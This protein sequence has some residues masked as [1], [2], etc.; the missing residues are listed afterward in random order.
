MAGI[1]ASVS[2]SGLSSGINWKDMVKQ[3]MASESQPLNALQGQQAVANGKQQ[4]YTSL[5]GNLQGLQTAAE[6]LRQYG[7]G[8]L[9]TVKAVSSD[10]SVAAA[11]AKPGALSGG[12]SLD[13]QALATEARA[14][15]GP[16]VYSSAATTSSAPVV[17]GKQGLAGGSFDPSASLSSESGAFAAKPGGSG[18][19]TVNGK[20]IRWTDSDS[21]GD[22][23]A[24][25][26]ASG[27]G[28]VAKI[29][30]DGT[31]TLTGAQSGA[32]ASIT[33]GESSGSLLEAL[34]MEPGRTAGSVPHTFDP[35]APL[36]S[37]AKFLGTPVTAGRVTINGVG[38][39]IDP[40]KQSLNDILHSFNDNG[41][42]VQGMFDVTD[43]QLQF[44]SKDQGAKARLEL[45]AVGDS[46]NFLSAFKVGD[47]TPGQDALVS[48]NGGPAQSLSS[49]TTD[50]LLPGASIALKSLGQATVSVG[51]SGDSAADA[52]QQFVDSYNT[53]VK[54][55]A[56][57]LDETPPNH[58]KKVDPLA[59]VNPDELN[60]PP[61]LQGAFIGDSLLQQTSDTL[62]DQVIG[63]LNGGNGLSLAQ[64][65]LTMVGNGPDQPQ[66]L[67]FDKN[68]FTAALASNPQAVHA[69]ISAP[70]TGLADRMNT[71][72]QGLLDPTNGSYALGIKGQTD[73]LND[74]NGQIREMQARLNDRQSRL[75]DQYSNLEATLGA[76]KAQGQSIAGTM[77]TLASAA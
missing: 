13:V 73:E 56:A 64:M 71:A 4:V 25:I 23:L 49:N 42:G 69:A 34:G 3:I 68:A 31:V 14:S 24:R 53:T 22:V 63:G 77:A 21:L 70:K 75:Q 35:T 6:S 7:G 9:D 55:V 61:T 76:M 26:N 51:P 67:K 27:A 60:A 1:P 29:G 36:A 43:G 2:L 39:D 52:V 58:T 17:S 47:V 15:S 16:G 72:L 57:K 44:M 11:S 30:S 45:G 66:T 50:A 8:A 48:V 28:V 59:P 5:E 62:A 20:E 38:F 65:G 54:A 32:N 74:L 41:V 19:I 12:V 40:T 18:T 33:L 46:S 10:D 37:Q